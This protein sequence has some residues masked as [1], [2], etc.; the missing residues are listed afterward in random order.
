MLL[1]YLDIHLLSGYELFEDGE[2]VLVITMIVFLKKGWHVRFILTIW[3]AISRVHEINRTKV[4]AF[5]LASLHQMH[6]H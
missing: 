2:V 4:L 3:A 5:R 6:G 1:D